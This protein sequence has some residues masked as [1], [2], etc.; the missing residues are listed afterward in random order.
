ADDDAP[1]EIEVEP[2]DLDDMVRSQ[3]VRS[4]F[5]AREE[6][7]R[8]RT[9]QIIESASGRAMATGPTAYRTVL[10][11]YVREAEALFSQTDAG[12]RYWSEYDF[13]TF[14]IVDLVESGS[15]YKIPGT[16][17]RVLRPPEGNTVHVRG[18]NS[19][20]ELGNPVEIAFDA[21]VPHPGLNRGEKPERT[22]AAA[23]IPQHILDKMF[24]ATNGYLS[25]IGLDIEVQIGNSTADADYSDII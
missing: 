20:F 25:E 23:Q 7:R 18:L 22:N 14:E 1:A 24:A 21:I 19:L 13:G 16:E 10:E 4:L 15:I 6:C 9:D 2:V 3:R 11:S 12:Q 8:V 17:K 5:N